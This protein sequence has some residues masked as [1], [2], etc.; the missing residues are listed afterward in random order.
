MSRNPRSRR[1]PSSRRVRRL[2]LAVALL[3]T[4]F[5][6]AAVAGYVYYRQR[7]GDIYHPHAA[8]TF[9]SPTA[10]PPAQRGVD[11]FAWPLYGYTADHQRNFPASA[12]MHPPYTRVWARGGRTLLEFPPVLYANRLFQL[13]DDGFLRAINKRTGHTFWSQRL[14]ILSASSPAVA[15]GTVYATV[16][17]RHGGTQGGAIVA[18]DAM[19]GWQRWSRNLP[20]AS[21]SSPLV[22]HG[23]VYFGSQS[24]TVYAL[25]IHSGKVVWTYHAGGAVKGSPTLKYGKLFFGDYSGHVQ[26]LNELTGHRVWLASSG[27]A[28]F[29][30][31]QFYST[32]AVVYGRVYLGNTDGR[33]YAYDS[34]TGRL[35]W[36]KQTGAYVYSSPAVADAPG[37]GP[38]IYI[39][40]YDGNFYALD[41]RS[42]H[43]RWTYHAGGRISGSP[44]VIG[45]IVYLADLGNRRTLG[46]GIST[47]HKQFESANGAFDPAISDGQR[48]YLT[49][50]TTLYAL[51]P[52]ASS[53]PAIAAKAG[54]KPTP[55]SSPSPTA[56][57]SP[58]PATPAPDV[59]SGPLAF[60]TCASRFRVILTSRGSGACGVPAPTPATG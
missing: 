45:R 19:R 29:G 1:L 21:E 44:T 58:S 18:L 4:M 60:S 51:A 26:A 13:A 41:A 23:R 31:G 28:V 40:S 16:M 39:G 47:G 32:P 12:T 34:G 35:D 52:A 53:A 37:L 55:G 10:L 24:G 20:S 17:Q 22:D 42:G 49:G 7:T 6:G 38:T 27:G 48:L 33:V 54:R 15:G 9:E 59:H 36:A 46:L 3:T 8:F 56:S 43:V 5:G 11:R 25:D 30:N 2:L 14:G 57:P 50:Y